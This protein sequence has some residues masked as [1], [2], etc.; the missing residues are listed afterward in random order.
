MHVNPDSFRQ[1]VRFGFNK[2]LYGQDFLEK[3]AYKQA[4]HKRIRFSKSVPYKIEDMSH[5]G[6]TVGFYNT[7]GSGSM[8]LSLSGIYAQ[9]EKRLP[10]VQKELA[11]GYQKVLDFD[12]DSPKLYYDASYSGHTLHLCK[13]SYP[14]MSFSGIIGGIQQKCSQEKTVSLPKTK[15]RVASYTVLRNMRPKTGVL[16]AHVQN[17]SGDIMTNKRYVFTN[18]RGQ[19]YVFSDASFVLSQDA[20]GRPLGLQNVYG[21]QNDGY[22][23]IGKTNEH[24]FF[25]TG[26]SLDISDIWI[27]SQKFLGSG[28]VVSKKTNLIPNNKSPL[29]FVPT[30]RSHKNTFSVYGNFKTG[31]LVHMGDNTSLPLQKADSY[32]GISHYKIPIPDSVTPGFTS[33]SIGTNTGSRQKIPA[34]FSHKQ[35]YH[36][37]HQQ[38]SQSSKETTYKIQ[39]L[40]TQNLPI[41]NGLIRYELI[42]PATHKLVRSSRIVS[43]DSQGRALIDTPKNI[44][45]VM[46]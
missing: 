42:N 44:P 30:Y 32:K 22:A 35:S 5:S 2:P 33:L 13:Q 12:T 23:R 20:N 18:A 1:G 21:K 31:V 3:S 26:A 34:F 16:Q 28:Q 15:N 6:F 4:L 39:A 14:Q 25:F 24:G 46:V 40:N 8:Y 41:S 19:G 43:L 7:V 29:L 27:Q 38:V 17:Q 10:S 9:N 36:V 11:L 37:K 45:L